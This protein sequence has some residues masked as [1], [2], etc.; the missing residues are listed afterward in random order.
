MKKLMQRG[1]IAAESVKELQDA[2]REL[3]RQVKR[4]LGEGRK[5]A[6]ENGSSIA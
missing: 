3:R 6:A 1:S 4:E 5:M 2:L